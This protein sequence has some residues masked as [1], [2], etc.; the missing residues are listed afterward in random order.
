M[1]ITKEVLT[2]ILKEDS[3][4]FFMESTE[5]IPMKY[6]REIANSVCD[7]YIK[8]HQEQGKSMKEEVLMEIATAISIHIPSIDKS[9]LY[10][11]GRKGVL[12]HR[13]KNAKT[14]QKIKMATVSKLASPNETV[15]T[16]NHQ[17]QAESFEEMLVKLQ[18]ISAKTIHEDGVQQFVKIGLRA[19][20][21][22]RRKRILKMKDLETVAFLRE[23]EELVLP[24]FFLKHEFVRN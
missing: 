7:F 11:G 4:H 12:F 15:P 20:F 22:E 3:L 23:Q 9:W 14:K 24:I 1:E 19:T 18:G 6:K 5:E 10:S 21:D 17:E 8:K 13:V 2:K 16:A